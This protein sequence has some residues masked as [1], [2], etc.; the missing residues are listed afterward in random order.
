MAPTYPR[1]PPPACALPPEGVLDDSRH[2][3][4]RPTLHSPASQVSRR[5]SQRAVSPAAA[6]SR[7]RLSPWRR[8]TA[9]APHP[10]CGG[11]VN[12]V[13]DL[14]AAV[15]MQL[16]HHATGGHGVHPG[17]SG[18]NGELA[19]LGAVRWRFATT[20]TTTA[21]ARDSVR[22]LCLFGLVPWYLAQLT[23]DDPC[24]LAALLAVQLPFHEARTV[25][26]VHEVQ[27]TPGAASG[28]RPKP[29][30]CRPPR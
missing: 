12:G 9:A 30:S 10:V 23:S 11:G 2:V 20:T 14:C 7:R 4:T 21:T 1:T 22:S 15:R 6:P 29:P 26:H 28:V 18:Q 5:A 25:N 13:R 16:A 17:S 27:V 24:R 8:H 19:W 3:R